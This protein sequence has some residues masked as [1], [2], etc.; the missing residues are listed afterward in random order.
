MLN[1]E[2]RKVWLT[3]DVKW[4]HNF[5]TQ[6]KGIPSHKFIL[7]FETQETANQEKGDNDRLEQVEE[8]EI[9]GEEEKEIAI[10]NNNSDDE[11]KYLQEASQPKMRLTRELKGLQDYN[12]PGL[13]DRV[14]ESK[15]EVLFCF[16]VA[17]PEEEIE[18]EPE[19]FQE[20]WY[21]PN[22]Q[23]R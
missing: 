7:D 23:I 18:K 4:L 5:Y 16:L 13:L 21:H 15:P 11:K 6:K 20:G 8:E 14:K 10:N 12:N 17:G 2:T 3:R 9:Q 1:L 22:P 19:T